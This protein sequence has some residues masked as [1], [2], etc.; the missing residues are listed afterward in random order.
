MN[1]LIIATIM[2]SSF[3][4]ASAKKV[5]TAK[6][7]YQKY[8]NP[9]SIYILN[10]SYDSDGKLFYMLSNDSNNLYVHAKFIEE[11]SQQ[12][13]LMNGFTIWVDSTAKA[14]HNMGIKFPLSP[15]DRVK[16]NNESSSKG[17][18]NFDKLK[19]ELIPQL[20]DIELINFPN[21]SKIAFISE[22]D[23]HPVKGKISQS[24]NGTIHYFVKIPYESIGLNYESG[25]IISLSLESGEMKGSGAQQRDSGGASMSMNGGGPPG[26]GGGGGPSGGGGRGPSGGMQ[27]G[28]QSSGGGTQG[29]N[30]QNSP[31]K[32]RIKRL[33]LL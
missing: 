9:D 10:Y 32:I 24:D 33:Q 22:L 29:A 18:R 2:I 5:V 30:Q 16:Q 13:L 7:E 31:I 6:W 15:Q 20:K 14:K 4:V 3:W 19:S 27:G 1:R 8:E 21:E 12:K 26:G 25:M 11:K 17:M 28:P 23:Q